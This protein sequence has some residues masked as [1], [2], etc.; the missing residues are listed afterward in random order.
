L[1]EPAEHLAGDPMVAAPLQVP[2]G[3]FRTERSAGVGDD[4]ALPV[5]LDPLNGLPAS[6]LTLDGGRPLAE[7]AQPCGPLKLDRSA[8]RP[9]RAKPAPAPE[10]APS[11]GT[12]CSCQLDSSVGQDQPLARG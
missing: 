11:T 12:W 8:R 4:A 7:L 1:L 9:G 10:S 6:T 5:L 2:V 3:R